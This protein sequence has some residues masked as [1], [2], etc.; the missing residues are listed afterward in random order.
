VLRPADHRS[1]ARRRR[2]TVAELTKLQAQY[3]SWL[4]ALPESL[5]DGPT[6]DA[7]QAICDRNLADLQA[8]ELPRSFARN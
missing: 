5:R 2:D 7:L 8:I 6:A 1:R 3:A 4:E